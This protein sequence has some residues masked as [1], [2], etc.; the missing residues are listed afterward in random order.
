MLYAQAGDGA[1]GLLP[2]R[3]ELRQNDEDGAE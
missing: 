3:G 1:C 2:V